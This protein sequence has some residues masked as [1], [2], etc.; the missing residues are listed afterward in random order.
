MLAALATTAALALPTH[1]AAPA[2]QPGVLSAE[3]FARARRGQVSFA[4]R[5]EC[6]AWGRRQDRTV[7]SASVIKAMLLVAYLQRGSV[8]DAP[9]SAGQRALLSP[10]IRRSDNAAATR[11]LALVGG[12]PRLQRDAERWGMKRF[13]AVEH[14]WG[15]SRI[16]ARDQARFFL[17]LDRRLP[18]RHRQYGLTLLRTIVPG[19]RW[20]VARVAPRGW[21]L[22]FKGGW[23]SGSGAVDHQVALL[24]RGD[25]RVALAI[26]TTAQ[27]SNAYGQRTLQGVAARLTRGLA[28]ATRVC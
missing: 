1:G 6:G 16:S 21:T 10:M 2:W 26:L 15:R 8:R 25:Q 18:P 27:G 3:R 11:V 22:H 14:P 4:V 28:H 9:L 12:A 23:G 13:T 17:H 24:T 19:Q 7:P 20:G 5:T